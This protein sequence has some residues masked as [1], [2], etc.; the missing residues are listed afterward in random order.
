MSFV[1]TRKGDAR[2]YAAARSANEISSEEGVGVGAQEAQAG[3][4]VEYP[5]SDAIKAQHRD[6]RLKG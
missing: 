1:R 3:D 5:L 6:G 2:T 4:V